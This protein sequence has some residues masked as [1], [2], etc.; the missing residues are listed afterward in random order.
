MQF[1]SSRFLRSS[2]NTKLNSKFHEHITRNQGFF[3]KLANKF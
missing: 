2:K 3:M 1:S